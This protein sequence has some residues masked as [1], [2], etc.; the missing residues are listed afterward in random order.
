MPPEQ[1]EQSSPVASPVLLQAA[2]TP[3]PADNDERPPLLDPSTDSY[4]QQLQA[5]RAVLAQV[6]QAQF[7]QEDESTGQPAHQGS[8]QESAETEG[9]RRRAS[10]VSASEDEDEHVE[11]YLRTGKSKEAQDEDDDVERYLRPV[12]EEKEEVKVEDQPTCR[13]C[14]DGPDEEVGN[15]LF[16]PCHCKG[17]MRY[18]HQACLEEWRKRS[19][20]TFFSCTSCGYEYKFRRTAAARVIMSKVTLTLLTA[21]I[22]LGLVV[23]SGFL[24]NTLLSMVEARQAVLSNSMFDEFF[25][26]DH[27]L[28][29]EGVREAVNFVGHQLEGISGLTAESDKL[30]AGD[31]EDDP[32]S[33]A[34]RYS[35]PSTRS[36]SRKKA[37]PLDDAPF[38]LRAIMHFVKGSSLI[39]ILSVFYTW[40][41]ASFI[42]PLGRTIFRAVRP[43]GAGRRRGAD[44][45]ANMSQIVIVALVVFGIIKSIR[46]TYMGVKWLTRKA[47]S[48]VEDLVL[49]V[50]AA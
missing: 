7:E 4:E 11:H 14:F 47:L 48:R 28:L 49:D 46:Q 20:R 15:K 43:V 27:I 37:A 16:S 32:E 33:T 22:F 36:R 19:R 39:G 40:V 26:P 3:L 8:E 5:R 30:L 41:A 24:A 31:D 10:V 17:T 34:Y 29:G 38:L 13:I 35:N 23:I 42:S 25:T 1:A 45:A 44:N 2:N 12:K 6:E 18:V 9:L 50:G 21:W